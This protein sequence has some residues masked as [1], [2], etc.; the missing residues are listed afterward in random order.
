MRNGNVNVQ[1]TRNMS[2]QRSAYSR[3][4]LTDT[5]PDHLSIAQP[6]NGFQVGEL[7]SHGISRTEMTQNAQQPDGAHTNGNTHIQMKAGRGK[8]T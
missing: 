2:A 4:K 5:P 1:Q 7:S 6:A 3:H 8:F